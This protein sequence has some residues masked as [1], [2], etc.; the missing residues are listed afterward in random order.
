MIKQI[1]ITDL[2]NWE[3]FKKG[4]RK[5]DNRFIFKYSPVCGISYSAEHELKTWLEKNSNISG[6]L[7]LVDVVYHKEISRL[8]AKE[9]DIKHE[10][11]QF[12][13]IDSGGKVKWH[14]DHSDISIKNLNEKIGSNIK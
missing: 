2:E 3:T 11:P 1:E 13:W 4:F 14:T 7:A 10:S 8:I 5:T 6:T 9:L 12:I